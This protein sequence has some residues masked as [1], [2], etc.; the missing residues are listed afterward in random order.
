MAIVIQ[1]VYHGGGVSINYSE[2]FYFLFVNSGHNL[3]HLIWRK[4]SSCKCF[5]VLGWFFFLFSEID[6]SH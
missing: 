6:G 3:V 1:M 5:G 4:H 2:F